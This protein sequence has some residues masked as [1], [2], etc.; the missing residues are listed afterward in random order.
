MYVGLHDAD[1]AHFKRKNKFPNYALMKISAYHKRR[2]DAV[3]WW[4]GEIFNN[5]YDRIY[6]AK[7]FDFTLENPFLPERTIKGGTG[8]NVKSCLPI[9]IDDM[10]PDYSIYPECDYAVGFLTRGCPN[11]CRW[12]V[13][14]EKE[15]EIRPYR[16]F[17]QLVRQDSDKLILMD[18]NILAIQ[19]GIQELISLIGS[20]YRIDLNQGMDA[21]LVTEDIAKIFSCLNWIRFIRFSCDQISQIEPIIRAAQLLERQG[22]KPSKLFIYLLVTKDLENAAYRVEQIKKLKSITIYA[23]AERNARAGILPNREQLEFCQRFIYGGC[24]RSESWS[25]YKERKYLHGEE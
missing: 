15:G 7:I 21:R 22:I 4:Q 20:P 10:Y 13:V 23:Q 19:H 14:P 3:E 24:Y 2:G 8:Y 9:E 1:A 6:S 17:E 18:N 16:Y 25:H 11:R 5:L 12:C